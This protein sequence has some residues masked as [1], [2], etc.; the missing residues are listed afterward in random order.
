MRFVGET[1]WRT[2]IGVV[3]DVLAH[4]LTRA[5]PEFIDGTL[6]VPLDDRR[7]ARRS[8]RLPAGMIAV[9][10]TDLTLPPCARS[11]RASRCRTGLADWAASA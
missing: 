2:V 9:I 4:D 1:Q 3:A 5:E 7:H 6:C 11:S 10:D 8:S